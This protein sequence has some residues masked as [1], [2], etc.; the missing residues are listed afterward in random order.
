MTGG[1]LRIILYV[2]VVSLP[3]I[4]STFFGH[5]E[6]LLNTIGLNLAFVGFMILILQFL[7]AARIKWVESAFGL[8]ILIRYH[9]YIALIAGLF[10]LIHPVMLALGGHGWRLFTNLDLPWY[11][12]L[13]KIALVL[14]IANLLLSIYSGKLGLAFEKWRTGHDILA[15]TILVLIFIHPF[16]AG[17]DLK[18]LS[19]QILWIL[20][21]LFAVYLFIYHRLYRPAKLKRMDYSVREVKQETGDVWTITLVPLEAQS[22]KD[23]LPGQFHFLTFFRSPGLPVEEH[24]WTISSS[25]A[26][27]DYI[28]STIK[29]SGDFTSTIDQ[30]RPGDTAAVHGPFGRFSYMLHP[31]ERDLVFIAGGIGITPLMAMLRHMRDTGDNRS[32]VLLYANRTRESIC[33]REELEKIASGNRPDLTLVHV[34]SRPEKDW[35]GES[36]HVDWE[37]IQKYCTPNPAGKTYYICAPVQMA[38]NLIS[39][40]LSKGVPGKQ[41]R[42]EIF[43][44]K[45]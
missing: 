11:I 20:M 28:S 8:D 41:L 10:L 32:V 36:G 12:W 19:M 30:T 14:V 15:P 42:R 24:H 38:E 1:L 34:L 4:I 31:E 21:F 18:L 17:D 45:D 40:L 7:L 43:S 6:G 16:F 25:P 23:Y 13:G 2:A 35:E 44:L 9:K 37:K 5:Q 22:L 39:I 33:F 3:V 26:N 29:A 27:R